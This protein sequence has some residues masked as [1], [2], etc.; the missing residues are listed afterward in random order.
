MKTCKPGRI[1]NSEEEALPRKTR[2]F[3]FGRND[4]KVLASKEHVLHVVIRLNKS[5]LLLLHLTQIPALPPAGT[6]YLHW[7]EVPQG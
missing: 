6:E 1:Q 2:M 7:T 5:T 3:V 4:W